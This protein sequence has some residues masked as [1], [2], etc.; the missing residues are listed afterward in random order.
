MSLST[1]KILLFSDF[2]FNMLNK[3][4]ALSGFWQLARHWKEVNAAKLEFA[5][6]DGNL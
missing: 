1:L 6:E 3:N 5:C 2:F 4:V